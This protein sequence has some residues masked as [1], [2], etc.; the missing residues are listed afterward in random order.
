MQVPP[1]HTFV[2]HELPVFVQAPA[3][4]QVCGW[5]TLQRAELG[6]H[7]PEHAPVLAVQT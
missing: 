7:S 6:W 3:A 5:S 2:V 1:L 4:E